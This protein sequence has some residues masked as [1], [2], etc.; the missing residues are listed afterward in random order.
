M[1][2][3]RVAGQQNTCS[4][5]AYK[6]ALT[7]ISSTSGRPAVTEYR[8]ACQGTPSDS[9][10]VWLLQ[11]FTG[12]GTAGSSVTPKPTDPGNGVASFA[13]AGEN[14]SAEPTYTS[15]EI[16]LELG[17]HMKAT[18]QWQALPGGEIFLPAS[19]NNGVGWQG[20]SDAYTGKFGAD[21]EF[22]D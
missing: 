18:Y 13:T 7:L 19:A 5:S 6:T 22:I 2:R 8:L 10:L 1:R 3:Y 11:R 21:C 15:G 12:V 16:M 14:H 9:V 17:L 20:K 4:T